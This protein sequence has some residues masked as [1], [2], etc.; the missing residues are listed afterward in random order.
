[1]A[2]RAFLEKAA[3]LVGQ[4]LPDMASGIQ[5]LLQSPDWAALWADMTAQAG[6]PLDA[7]MALEQ[8]GS[9]MQAHIEL[10][11]GQRNPDAFAPTEWL[12]KWDDKGIAVFHHAVNAQLAAWGYDPQAIV[13]QWRAK[14]WLKAGEG[15][16]A[17]PKVTICGQ[18]GR[19]AYVLSG[20][21]MAVAMRG[22]S[23]PEPESEDV[24]EVDTD[25][26]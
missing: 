3:G 21:G 1:M 26:E 9:W 7:Q 19:N 15:R 20:D 4:A 12:G 11:E 2:H 25:T 13:S 24:T 18:R 10:F 8:L 14:G 22:T 6:D 16:N 23:Q 5:T 17:D